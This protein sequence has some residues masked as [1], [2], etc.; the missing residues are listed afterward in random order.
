MFAAVPGLG[1]SNGKENLKTGPGAGGDRP[2]VDGRG[3]SGALIQKKTIE[4]RTT[5]TTI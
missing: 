2:D 5:T 4:K 3:A 1:E